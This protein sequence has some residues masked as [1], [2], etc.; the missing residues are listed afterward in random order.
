M[1][2]SAAPASDMPRLAPSR[3][4]VPVLMRVLPQALRSRHGARIGEGL[5]RADIIATGTDDTARS[6]RGA[7]FAFAIRVASAFI[8]Y[9][10][11]IFVA[12]WLGEH[13]YGVFV[14]VWTAMIVLSLLVSLGFPSA[15]VRFVPEHRVR[16]EEDLLRG[17]L[18]GSRLIGFAGGTAAAL[19]GAAL[20]WRFGGLMDGPYHA[21]FALCLICLPMLCLGSV[22]DGIARAHDWI[23]LALGATYLVRPLLILAFMLGAIAAGLP[24]DARTAVLAA[25]AATWATSLIQLLLLQ[26][27]LARAVPRGPRAYRMG[28]WFKV[29]LP[30]FLVEGFYQLLTN[31]DILIAGAFV[32]PERVAVYFAAVKTLAL[33]HFVYFA[34]KAGAAH[35]FAAYHAGGDERALARFAA[36]TV[37]WTFWPTVAVTAVLL[38][39]GPFLLSLFGPRFSQGQGLLVILS[40]GIVARAAVGPA[41]SVLTMAGRQMACAALYATTLGV[42]VALNL[43]L[44]PRYGLEGAAIATAAAMCFEAVVLLAVTRRLLG[45]TMFVFA[46]RAAP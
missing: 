30:I 17:F 42:N 43:I 18:R 26:R 23:D 36:D 5:A 40:V 28:A 20:V 38:V 33:A 15:A 25:I 19:L 9:I 10:S 22:Q 27:R 29:A 8:A 31:V 21:L 46:P 16:G 7:L 4:A 32:A 37:R 1:R 6:Q 12:R 39:C 11:Q 13:D 14:W 34:V 24:G 44:I 35:R 45:F 2:A 41:E 3:L